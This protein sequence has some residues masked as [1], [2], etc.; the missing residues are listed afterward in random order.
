MNQSQEQINLDVEERTNQI[1]S[2][3][4]EQRHS[5]DSERGCRMIREA[6]NAAIESVCEQ[7]QPM[8]TQ[9]DDLK[10]QLK[11]ARLA[12]KKSEEGCD[13]MNRRNQANIAKLAKELA[14]LREKV[15]EVN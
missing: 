3:V 5:L 4:R 8:L 6:I 13:A 12:L 14:E 10:E 15:I 9:I 1:W 11:A 2:M 7:I